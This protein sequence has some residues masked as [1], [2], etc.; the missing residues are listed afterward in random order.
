MRW[1]GRANGTQVHCTC[2]TRSSLMV[3][4]A[5]LSVFAGVT[6]VTPSRAVLSRGVRDAAPGSGLVLM[7]SSNIS[8]T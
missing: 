7:P 1:V 4:I 5:S 3:D 6:H 2:P 8:T